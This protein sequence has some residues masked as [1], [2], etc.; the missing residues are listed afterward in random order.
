M[1]RFL[2]GEKMMVVEGNKLMCRSHVTFLFIVLTFTPLI[3]SDTS[4]GVI[5]SLNSAMIV[6]WLHSEAQQ[7][8]VRLHC[9]CWIIEGYTIALWVQ[10]SE[11]QVLNMAFMVSHL[12]SPCFP[13]LTLHHPKLFFLAEITSRLVLYQPTPDMHWSV[14]RGSFRSFC[15]SSLSSEHYHFHVLL[16]LFTYTNY[17][18]L[19]LRRF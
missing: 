9:L 15:F 17:L 8:S 1:S 16:E 13:Q 4:E 6:F 19:P 11:G 5:S 12:K 18:D 3:C 14:W 2:R 7:L 10:K